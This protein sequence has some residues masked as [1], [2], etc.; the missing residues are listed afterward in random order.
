MVLRTE[1]VGR[2]KSHTPPST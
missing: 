1:N 2:S